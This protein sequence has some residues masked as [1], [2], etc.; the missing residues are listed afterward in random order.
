ME[1]RMSLLALA[2][3]MCLL[4]VQNAFASDAGA[5]GASPTVL[6]GIA[7]MLLMANLFSEIFQYL[8]QPSVLG[9]LVAGIILGNLF[10][11]GFEYAEVLKTNVV[12]STMAQLGIIIL[13]FEVGLETDFD[14]MKKVGWSSFL[15]AIIGVILPFF[16]GWGVAR[17]FLGDQA[18]LS[19]IFIGAMLC[20]TSIGIT[21]RVF[22]DMGKINAREAKIILGAAVID[23]V[24]A[25]L[26]LAIVEGAI[27]SEANGTHLEFMTFF[28]IALKAVGFLLIASVI[29]KIF[30]PKIFVSVKNFESKGMVIG[31]ALSICFIFAWAASMVGL[32]AIIGAFAAGLVLEDA[33]FEHFLD[34]KK[35]QLEDFLS[36][37]TAILAPIFFVSIGMK[38]DLRVFEKPEILIFAGALT[39]AAIIGKQACSLGVLEKGL[40]K[41]AIGFGMVPRGEVVLFFAG[42]G[43]TLSLPNEQNIIVPVINP[44]TFSAIVILVMITALLTPPALKWSLN[45]TITENTE[46]SD[47]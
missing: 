7:V 36:P 46:Q 20:A 29:G 37:M 34:H 5:H 41:L 16:L 2:F 25:L 33:S 35:H 17:M 42:V 6:I 31:L 24:L 30:V 32:A 4:L 13:L 27:F 44:S 21:A 14:D 39:L 38:V 15:V 8:G 11:V 12:I 3:I 40:N 22:K 18:T 9:E 45:R 1:R 10:L 23:D 43:A 28:I 47:P 19:H 26:I